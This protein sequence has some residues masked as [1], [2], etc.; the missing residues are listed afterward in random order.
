MSL[1]EAVHCQQ[2]PC[3]LQPLRNV[4]AVHKGCRGSW[5]RRRL[6]ITAF[7]FV[8]NHL[9]CL[10]A[11]NLIAVDPFE[12]GRE[13]RHPG[14][15]DRCRP[16]RNQSR[17][18]APAQGNLNFMA[19]LQPGQKASKLLPQIPNARRL[20]FVK[21]IVSQNKACQPGSPRSASPWATLCSDLR[22]TPARGVGGQA[23][24]S[25]RHNS[26]PAAGRKK[27]ALR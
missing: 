7:V 5:Y 4:P 12:S 25:R 19:L 11:E 15:R 26:L 1:E 20:H 8:E 6:S 17:H 14:F 21:H 10:R 23:V 3:T 16:V 24:R 27:V 2:R 9:R 13:I 18:D 22:R